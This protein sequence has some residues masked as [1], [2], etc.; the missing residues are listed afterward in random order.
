[1]AETSNYLLSNRFYQKI[2]DALPVLLF[3]TDT[4]HIILGNNM[5]H[6]KAF[7]FSSPEQLI[8]K[9]INYL[10]QHSPV[11][12]PELA[13][14]CLKEHNE[15]IQT[16][17]GK[18]LEYT[19]VMADNKEHTHLSYKEPLLDEKG[20]VI[21][22]VGISTDITE[23]KQAR[24]N[25]RDIFQ[26]IID[27]LP[28]LLFWTD[29]DLT[30]IGNNSPHAQ[31]FGFS[32]SKQMI[33]KSM[34]NFGEQIGLTNNSI[35][36]IYQDHKEI[37]ETKKGKTSEYT[38]ILADGKE[39]TH[40]SKKEPLL[41]E[42]D[43]AIGVI[44][45]SMD[46]TELKETQKKLE[47]SNAVK[48]EFIANMSH[49]M[50]TPI[51]GIMGMLTDL[52]DC[53]IEIET[54]RDTE[55]QLG[56]NHT[57]EFLEALL[58]KVE[59]NS[60]VAL[61]A[62]NGLLH[63][64]NEILEAARLES[65]TA[66]MPSEAFN[67]IAL[68]DT[69]MSLVKPTAFEKNLT[70]TEKIDHHIPQYL[71][72]S[73]RYLSKSLLNLISNALKFTEKGSITVSLTLA[74]TPK[75]KLKKGDKVNLTICVA[76]TGIGIPKDKFETIFEH[77]SKLNPSYKGV[78]K[79]YGLGLYTVKQYVEAMHGTINV[80][81]MVGKGTQFILT[82][83]FT[84]DD[85]T[86]HIKPE[87][88]QPANLQRPKVSAQTF[89]KTQ[90][91]ANTRVLLVE[92]T[93]V[94][95]TVAKN[96]LKKCGCQSV[97]DWAQTGEIALKKASENHYDLILMDIG[98][99][100]M[101]GTEVTAKIRA[102]DDPIKSKVPIVALTG[103]ADPEQKKEFQAL[104]MN[105]LIIKPATN[106]NLTR[107]LSTYVFPKSQVTKPVETDQ[108]DQSK[109]ITFDW[110]ATLKLDHVKNDENILQEYLSLMSDELK[111][112]K[113][114][115]IDAYKNKDEKT[116]RAELHR[117]RGALTY[118]IAPE[119]NHTL[120]AFHRAVRAEP[121]DTKVLEETYQA[122]IAAIDHFQRAYAK[123]FKS[124]KFA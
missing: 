27:T 94:A 19:A 110:D 28:V 61:G 122:A 24:K 7:G 26:K 80:E 22:L 71:F 65:H 50:R 55:N 109:T 89:D 10:F 36:K 102:L 107:V 49:D 13:K 53:T 58:H 40:L 79:G 16:K 97:I 81:S 85:H 30:I 105:D 106:A 9:S 3:W 73:A 25:A 57:D 96:M 113:K 66:K 84:V 1:M 8:G 123:G 14:R 62:V 108:S 124:L 23:L 119:L 6:A 82:L 59:N 117:V 68:I 118:L 18:T 54:K 116:L 32:S 69:V 33:G 47:I 104:G 93:S 72:G 70:L 29:K 99:P 111:P 31:A 92:D 56:I 115:L 44:G 21:G 35:D 2:H 100:K 91:H 11:F 51:T 41:D 78:Y 46:I 38:N 74:S 90:P 4:K 34:R 39:H 52:L 67:L 64:C 63:L 15:I 88:D 112:T 60:H 83:P 121:Q 5:P 43:N 95:A 103:H 87:I 114:I 42:K 77:F 86:D 20:R 12:T 17:K 101:Q 45:I 48:K 120:E 98:L 76:D 37:L 75:G